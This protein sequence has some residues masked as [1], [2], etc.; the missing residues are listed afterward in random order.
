MPDA[1]PQLGRRL[2]LTGLGSLPLTGLAGEVRAMASAAAPVDMA[3]ILIAGPDGG[4][5]DRWGRTV[6]PALA[7]GLPPEA[8]LRLNSVG[9][10]DGVTGANQFLARG[11]PDGHT[12]LLAP[13]DAAMAW[14]VG[15]PRAQYDVARWVPV[16][17]GT[18]AAVVVVRPD[19]TGKRDVRIATTG[20]ATADLPALLGLDILGWPAVPV[21]LPTQEARF[22]ALRQGAVDAVFL[23]GHKVTELLAPMIR[24]GLVPLFSL[25]AQDETGKP[26]RCPGLPDVPTLPEAYTAARGPMPEGP[27]YDSWR[28][29]AGA[30][31]LD[32]ALVLPHLT[33]AATVALW[34]RAGTEAAAA[35]DVRRIALELGVRLIGGADAAAAGKALI[36]PPQAR[37]ELRR[38]LAIRFDWRPA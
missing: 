38:W 32:F 31:Q 11:E 33:P 7:Q 34:R 9:A 8:T 36:A 3:T 25:G 2:L 6:Q 1:L 17:A 14:L 20:P 26:I 28:S 19:A 27:L 13:G 15:D 35:L 5:L 12:V 29:S 22:A 30:A 18:T 21:V 10:A 4:S 37:A 23:R 24:S 16:M